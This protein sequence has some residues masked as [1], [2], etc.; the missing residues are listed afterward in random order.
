MSAYLG[1]ARIEAQLGRASDSEKTLLAARQASP[2]ALEPR[3]ALFSFYAFNRQ[4]VAALKT[5]DG[6]IADFRRV[7]ALTPEG[8]RGYNNLGSAYYLK[9]DLENAASA[10]RQALEKA[11]FASV[12]GKFRFGPNHHPVQDLYVREVV[13]TEDGTI[14]NRT[15]G[16][17]FTDHADAYAPECRM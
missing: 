8:S 14:T 15:L 16:V 1:K 11:D 9:G 7:T 6:A 2:E 3:L 13:K 4:A 5:I 17:V 12:R 10:F